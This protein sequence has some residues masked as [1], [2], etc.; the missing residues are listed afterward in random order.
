LG[1]V[2]AGTANDALHIVIVGCG[3]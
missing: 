2:V 3:M 1:I